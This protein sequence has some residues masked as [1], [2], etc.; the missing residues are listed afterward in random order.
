MRLAI[1]A[2]VHGNLEALEAVLI[3]A[4]RER[5]DQIVVLGDLVGYGPDPVAC[6]Y[7]IRE[8]EGVCVLG[9]HDQ[10]LV[11]G[12]R[13]HELNALARD[14]ILRSRD[15]VGE[16]E[17][18][19]LRTFAFRHV[20]ADGVFSHANPLRPEE[21]Q[22]LYLFH[23]VQWCLDRLEW[24][25]AFV[26]H[27][28]HP[29]IFCRME[30]AAVPLTSCEVAVGRHRYLINAGSVGQPRDGDPRAC[31]AVWDVGGEHVELLREEYPVRRTQ[32]KIVRLGWPTYAAERLARGE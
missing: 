4:D 14:T 24:R 15:L 2:D 29:G 1:L 17:L 22:H 5:V 18:D 23:H 30:S 11:D 12:H 25:I 20:E 26:G 6:I 19:Y 16:E 32:D 21:W 3:A 8:A 9:N 28:H 27:T 10:A 31:F 7:R 13:V